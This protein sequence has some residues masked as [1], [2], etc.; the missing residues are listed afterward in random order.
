MRTLPATGPMPA[1]LATDRQFRTALPIIAA[2]IGYAVFLFAP[3]VLNDGDTWWQLAAGQ[4][5]LHH[6]A[7]PFTDHFSYT[8]AGVPWV[9]QEWLSEVLTALAYRGGGWDGVLMLYGAAAALTFG[10]LALH[11]RRW[12]DGPCLLLLLILGAACT[13]GS[14]LV[15]PHLLALPVLELWTAGLLIARSR[16]TAP[17]L[18][19]LPLMVLWAN[20]HGSFMLGLLLPFP[21]ALEAVVEA[22]PD[23]AAVLRGW[24]GFILGGFLAA[25]ANPHFWH[26]LLF[27]FHLL[28]M[29]DLGDI[30][31]WAPPD[32]AILQ[33][34]EVAL[35]VFLYATLSR[36]IRLPALRLLL[37][38]GLLYLALTH[39]RHDM[40]A[41]IIGALLLA[42]PL[43]RA[44]GAP[45]RQES[46]AGLAWPIAG[47]AAL[48][49]LTGL[50]LAHPLVRGDNTVSP[51]AALDHV[52]PAIVRT[53][54]FNAYDFGGYL[55]FRGIPPFIDGRADLYGGRFMS[56]YLKAMQPDMAEF[57]RLVRRYHIHWA[58]LHTGSPLAGV[59]PVL[60]G[61]RLL[62][63]DRTAVVFV[64]RG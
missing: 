14:L 54:V 35:G 49:L 21:L 20:L 6:R 28:A 56:A 55:I 32:F 5:I 37:L 23:R 18:W 43:G 12:T 31:E 57:D 11:L 53:P 62:Y 58:I 46:T 39:A 26:L 10:M 59:L 36:G 61:W 34:I 38:I 40:L 29:K 44:F 16:R 50:R 27:P 64:R 24:A 22:G 15:R 3:Q 8:F 47:L 41:G 63:G 2:L 19:L 33:P 48:A 1:A 52:P 17:S 7:I 4:W 13:S 30:T 45:D 9:A 25:L 51:I 42:E 60:P